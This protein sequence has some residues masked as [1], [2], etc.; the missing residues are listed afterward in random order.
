MLYM[1]DEEEEEDDD[2]TVRG[3]EFQQNCASFHGR[4][5]VLIFV[6]GVDNGFEEEEEEEEDEQEEE[7]EEEEEEEDEEEDDDEE[8]E[9]DDDDCVK[10][11]CNAT[12]HKVLCNGQS[13]F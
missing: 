7:E 8:E 3:S 2:N 9:E 11:E 1:V 6:M 12:T 10:T 5:V 13:N 4:N